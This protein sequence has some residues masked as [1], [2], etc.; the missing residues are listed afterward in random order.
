MKTLRIYNYEILNFDPQ[1]IVFS[2]AGFTRITDPKL[3]KAL[4]H[5]TER[6]LKH[7]PQHELEQ[8]FESET[9][10]P[11]SAISFLKSIL[12]IG[13][14]TQLPHFKSVTA[15]IDW[16]IPD[17]LKEHIE[18]RTENKLKITRPSELNTD[19]H[20]NPTLFVLAYSKLKPEELRT[21][22]S[23]LSK[24]NPDS[25]ISVGFISN[26]FFH[27]TEAYIPSIGNPCAFCTLD[28]IT[29]YERLRASQ[30]HWSKI[31]SF[32]QSNKIDL[33]KTPIDELQS[34]LILGTIVSFTNK[35]THFQ[36][37]KLTQ[38]QVLLSRTLNL[39]DGS[40][41]EDSSIHWS[42]C[43]CIGETL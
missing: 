31:W 8:I 41:S 14:P 13:E 12:I 5:L 20:P 34:A 43:Q 6:Q 21:I 24:N 18:N 40:F 36:K 1:P 27:L 28:R 22:Y 39:S 33:P 42:L 7:I 32:C 25:G 4:K 9:L 3:A 2:T 38:D 30:H 23:K 26:H 35:L 16:E 29:H 10:Q 11:E 17:T 15:C 19:T 37:S